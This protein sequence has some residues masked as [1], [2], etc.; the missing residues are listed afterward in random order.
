MNSLYNQPNAVRL[1]KIII[2]VKE[3]FNEI[4]DFSLASRSL[5]PYAFEK[6]LFRMVLALGKIFLQIFFLSFGT[7][8][9]GRK[10]LTNDDEI[11]MRYRKRNIDYISIFGNIEID[12][13]YYWKKGN[14]AVV[15]NKK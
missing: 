7:G 3:K 2:E 9:V 8:D 10:I 15:S 4:L 14:E 11:L 6:Q 5:T 1:E 13:Y 12:R